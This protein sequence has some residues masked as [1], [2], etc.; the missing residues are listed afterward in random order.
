MPRPH[1][2]AGAGAPSYIGRGGMQKNMYKVPA[3]QAGG[4][5]RAF[6]LCCGLFWFSGTEIGPRRPKNRDPRDPRT[7]INGK[8]TSVALRRSG[9]PTTLRRK[10]PV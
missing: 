10:V 9:G 1:Q 7:R 5:G 8:S 2:E 3:R 4:A 6:C